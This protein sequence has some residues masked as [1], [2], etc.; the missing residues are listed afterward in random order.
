M[1]RRRFEPRP[2]VSG[3]TS[4]AE[5]L[6]AA[7]AAIDAPSERAMAMHV[8][9]VDESSY[10]KMKNGSREVSGPMRQLARAIVRDPSLGGFY[11]LDIQPAGRP[12]PTTPLV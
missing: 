8:Y 2:P 9:D 11:L 4:D 1:P 12:W 3:Y 5:L 10:R 7:E 6:T